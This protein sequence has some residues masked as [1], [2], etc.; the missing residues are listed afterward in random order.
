MPARSSQQHGETCSSL[1]GI[2]ALSA[3]RS[4]SI[5]EPG[6]VGM[7]TAPSLRR[8]LAGVVSGGAGNGCLV[9]SNSSIGCTRS[10]E[11]R[12]GRQHGRQLQRRSDLNPR[13]TAPAHH[14]DGVI[15]L[16]ASNIS[17]DEPALEIPQV[18]VDPAEPLEREPF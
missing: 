13:G 7:A 3:S 17:P 6:P 14:R 5:P 1:A 10:S 4:I 12:E 15:G 8:H 11:E 18:D 16:V 9:R 2:E